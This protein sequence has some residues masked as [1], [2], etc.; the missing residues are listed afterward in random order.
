MTGLEHLT[1]TEADRRAAVG[2][3]AKRYAFVSAISVVLVSLW[4][5]MAWGGPAAIGFYLGPIAIG[6]LAIT[7]PPFAAT[8]AAWQLSP[9]VHRTV[10]RTLVAVLAVTAWATVLLLVSAVTGFLS[11]DPPLTIARAVFGIAFLAL[12]TFVPVSLSLPWGWRREPRAA[13]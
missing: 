3:A 13:Q 9:W 6:Y 11:P 8:V 12:L 7:A 1:S 4:V 10:A 2:R 5:A